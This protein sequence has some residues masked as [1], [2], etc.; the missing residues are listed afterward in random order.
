MPRSYLLAESV[1]HASVA[2]LMCPASKPTAWL[3]LLPLRLL[4]D[5]NLKRAYQIGQKSRK[6]LVRVINVLL[7][8]C[9]EYLIKR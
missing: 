2:D 8:L 9:K 3:P 7:S 6:R 1:P 5:F 4:T